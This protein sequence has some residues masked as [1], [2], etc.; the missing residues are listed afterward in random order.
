MIGAI[1]QL[2]GQAGKERLGAGILRKYVSRVEFARKMLSEDIQH[3]AVLEQFIISRVGDQ[4]HIHVR[5]ND[6]ILS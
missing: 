6:Y 3:D 2:G 1:F 4:N 5:I